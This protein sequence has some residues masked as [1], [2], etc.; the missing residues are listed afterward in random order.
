TDYSYRTNPNIC[1]ECKFCYNNMHHKSAERRRSPH[2]LDTDE[3]AWKPDMFDKPIIIS[4]FSEPFLEGAQTEASIKAA[5]IIIRNGGKFIF[6]TALDLPEK[7][8][9]LVKAN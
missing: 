2:Y 1:L 9:E 6:K 8:L 3:L 5:E 7:A 4:R